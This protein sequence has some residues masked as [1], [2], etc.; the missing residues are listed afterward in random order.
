M[1]NQQ[2][3]A[4]GFSSAEIHQLRSSR[5]WEGETRRV[6]FLRG[7]PRTVGFRLMLAVLDAGG[8]AALSHQS[9][10][11]WWGV[12]GCAQWPLHLC[13]TKSTRHRTE[14]AV[15]HEVRR[16]PPRWSVTHRGVTI[17][18]PELLAL[19]LFA[20][21]HELQA[22]RWVERLWGR[23]LLS[24]ASIGRFL[25][26]MGERGR[27]GTAP[28]RQYLNARPPGYIPPAS[29]L[30]SRFMQ[31]VRRIGEPFDRQVDSGDEVWT[32]RVDFRHSDLPVIA[33]IQSEAFHASLVDTVADD[34]RLEQLV[35]DGFFVVEVWDTEVWTEPDT[36]LARV[37]EALRDA[38]TPGS[39][40][41]IYR[42]S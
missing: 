30:E 11:R 22:E 3:R 27:N 35:A 41:R 34:R 17:V 1:S 39:V 36:V 8:D 9:A 19:Q 15:T 25:S 10:G 29:G 42:K 32:G 12:G 38:R 37:G 2:A 13:T 40:P 31:L 16:V 20:T 24:G 4:L 33:E 28:L 18:R 7:A 6:F 5:R 21:C 26:D 14:L 23:R